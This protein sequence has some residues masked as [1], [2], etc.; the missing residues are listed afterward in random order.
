MLIESIA[1]KVIF[2]LC[3]YIEIISYCILH[4]EII[5]ELFHGEQEFLKSSRTDATLA[6]VLIYKHFCFHLDMLKTISLSSIY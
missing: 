3:L 6:L 5:N 4:V 1:A 2:A